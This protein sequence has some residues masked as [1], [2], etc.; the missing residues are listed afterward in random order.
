M[1]KTLLFISVFLI[2]G[3]FFFSYAQGTGL[4]GKA[5]L[6]DF[7]NLYK[8]SNL[9]IVKPLNI[10][11][12]NPLDNSNVTTKYTY[13]KAVSDREATCKY[14]Y[15]GKSKDF[16]E[17]Q[18]STR[19]QQMETTGGTSHSQIIEN[20]QHNFLY[21]VKLSCQAEPED[22]ITSSST[23][24]TQFL[25]Q[26]L[27]PVESRGLFNPL[28]GGAEIGER[29][30]GYIGVL[31]KSELRNLL[32]DI[33]FEYLNESRIMSP[34]IETG[35]SL[36]ENSTSNGDLE[37]PA[38]LIEVG[39]NPRDYV[40]RYRMYFSRNIKFEFMRGK[41]L[42]I[43]GENY[44]VSQNST[45]EMFIL[46]RENSVLTFL[47]DQPAIL[48]NKTINGTKVGFKFGGD[49]GINTIS[50]NFTMQD[51]NKDY[52]AVGESY[53]DP[54][55]RNIRIGFVSYNASRNQYNEIFGSEI[56]VGSTK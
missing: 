51:P 39:T 9:E 20:L 23:T 48:N 37:Y 17:P 4:T 16:N 1:N 44:T 56:Y 15:T 43:V 55:F 18:I 30:A 28:Y 35:N 41:T 26:T 47:N 13:I 45:N 19:P 40:Y 38:V 6:K 54:F 8:K 46:E 27:L 24:S 25:T 29:Y 21:E 22:K 10:T 53:D 31:T 11:I 52:I 7:F 42:Q 32:A 33:N 12:T 36:I 50:V 34:V 5:T 49:G 14:S 2:I 3:V